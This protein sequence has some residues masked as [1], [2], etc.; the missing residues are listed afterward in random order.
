MAIWTQTIVSVVVVSLIS[1]VG[2]LFLASKDTTDENSDSPLMLFLIALAV[3]ALLGDVFIHLWPEASE[4]LGAGAAGYLAAGFGLFFLIEKLLHWRHQHGSIK[5]N[6]IEPYGA[7][8]LIGDGLHNFIDGALIAA[9]YLVS[10]PIGFATTI[11]V[12]LHEI[13]QELGDYAILRSAGFSKQRA[14]LF[15]F[16]SALAAVAGGVIVLA[17]GIDLANT[18]HYILAFTAGG[19]IYIAFLLL[20][21]LGEDLT[22]GKAIGQLAA[23]GLGALLMWAVKFVE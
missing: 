3:G 2:A 8:N 19:F 7:M 20:K 4:Q 17:S 21:K 9:S 16:L 11:A 5:E 10:F 14:V 1:L 18:A 13:P 6:R 15:N 23:F 12:I 22:F